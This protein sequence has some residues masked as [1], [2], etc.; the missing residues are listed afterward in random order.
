VDTKEGGHR[1]TGK[2]SEKIVTAMIRGY[3]ETHI[4]HT[5]NKATW[6]VIIKV[7]WADAR[8]GT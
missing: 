2:T 6:H 1:I 7:T 4:W 5:A 8:S 3:V